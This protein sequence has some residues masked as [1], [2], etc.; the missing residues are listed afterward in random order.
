MNADLEIRLKPLSEVLDEILA[1]VAPIVRATLLKRMVKVLSGNLRNVDSVSAKVEEVVGDQGKAVVPVILWIGIDA[2]SAVCLTIQFER[3][4]FINLHGVDEL[5]MSGALAEVGPACPSD[6]V[7]FIDHLYDVPLA[8]AVL[9][10]RQC[11]EAP[12]R[13]RSKAVV[14]VHDV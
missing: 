13:A 5:A 3:N 14:M 9:A 4:D 11:A 2:V 1:E 8:L 7:P 10:L 6:P 12:E